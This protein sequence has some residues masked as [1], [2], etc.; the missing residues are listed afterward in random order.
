[1]AFSDAGRSNVGHCLF[2]VP[3]DLLLSLKRLDLK[4]CV[5]V[6]AFWRCFTVLWVALVAVSKVN[7]VGGLT[8]TLTF[9]FYFSSSS[10]VVRSA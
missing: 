2:F 5:R 6:L 3:V 4:A 1:M 10:C 9:N 8:F 7:K